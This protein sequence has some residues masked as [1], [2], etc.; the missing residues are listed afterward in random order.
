M[1]D[2]KVTESEKKDN[3]EVSA[4]ESSSYPYGLRIYL[5]P[6]DVKKLGLK[7]PQVGQKLVLEANCEILSVNAE[8]VKGDEKELSV[9]LQLK[10]MSFESEEKEKAEDVIYGD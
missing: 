6:D 8:I 7:D 4:L 3:A 9:S 5:S 1:I 10:E 2:M